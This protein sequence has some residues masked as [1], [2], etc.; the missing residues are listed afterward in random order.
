[1]PAEDS[2][3]LIERESHELACLV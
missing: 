2:G 1:E 3:H